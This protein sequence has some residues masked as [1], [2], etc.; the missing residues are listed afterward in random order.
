MDFALT[1]DTV[2]PEDGYRGMIRVSGHWIFL[3]SED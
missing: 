3:T 1:P 2:L